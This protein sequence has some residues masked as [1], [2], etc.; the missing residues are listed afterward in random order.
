MEENRL[1]PSIH[2]VEHRG[3]QAVLF[4]G[5]GSLKKGFGCY[6]LKKTNQKKTQR[7]MIYRFTCYIIPPPTKNKFSRPLDGFKERSLRFVNSL[8]K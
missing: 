7:Q 2:S 5:G 3:D 8:E 1:H 6:L 4:S